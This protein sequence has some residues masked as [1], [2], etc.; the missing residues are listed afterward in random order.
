VTISEVH[1]TVHL[2]S[3]I[4]VL[5]KY[6]NNKQQTFCLLQFAPDVA[7]AQNSLIFPEFMTC[8]EIYEDSRFVP[9]WLRLHIPLGTLYTVLLNARQN[10]SSNASLKPVNYSLCFQL[11]F[12]H[13]VHSWRINKLK[14]DYSWEIKKSNYKLSICPSLWDIIYVA[15][16]H[17]PYLTDVGISSQQHLLGLTVAQRRLL[18][19]INEPKLW[20]TDD[21]QTINIEFTSEN[22]PTSVLVRV[23]NTKFVF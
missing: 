17:T 1:E 6:L 20:A 8:T 12:C 10:L 7:I 18:H 11:C 16:Y 22:Y 9:L 4:V 5:H 3:K 14:G 21:T 19:V 15:C 13:H 23:I 2:K